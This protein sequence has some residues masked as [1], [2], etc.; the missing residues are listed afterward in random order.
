M[1]FRKRQSLRVLRFRDKLYFEYLECARPR[2]LR[3]PEKCK[4]RHI[5]EHA[6]AQHQKSNLFHYAQNHVH[7]TSKKIVFLPCC[8]P[9]LFCAFGAQ[10]RVQFAWAKK[11]FSAKS[12]NCALKTIFHGKKKIFKGSSCMSQKVAWRGGVTRTATAPSQPLRGIALRSRLFCHLNQS[13]CSPPQTARE[14][15][16]R[17]RS[18]MHPVALFPCCLVQAVRRY[19]MQESLECG[20]F[21]VR[22]AELVFTTRVSLLNWGTY[23]KNLSE[24][25]TRNV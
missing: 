18:I 22:Y 11:R 3:T 12:K 9:V 15:E 17:D 21:W 1:Y 7:Q 16:F 10:N 25:I 4:K 2:A 8:E 19:P 13:P 14:P 20:R 24:R 23:A 5:E 6:V